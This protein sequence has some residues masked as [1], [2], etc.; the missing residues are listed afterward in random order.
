[1]PLSCSRAGCRWFAAGDTYRHPNSSGSGPTQ[2]ASGKNCAA[3]WNPRPGARG[4][5]GELRARAERAER[6]LDA[7]RAELARARQ[8]TGA[9]ETPDAA[10]RHR[11]GQATE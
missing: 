6:D 10:S 7:A 11:P 2:P 9:G 1:M 4:I 8:G 5:N 3:R